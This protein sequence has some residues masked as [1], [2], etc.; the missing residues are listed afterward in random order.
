MYTAAYTQPP[1]G[2]DRSADR[3]F[4]AFHALHVFN[5][6]DKYDL[7]ALARNASNKFILTLGCDIY[8][9][10]FE[11]IIRELYDNCPDNALSEAMR[12]IVVSR[13]VEAEQLLLNSSTFREIIR[14][15]VLFAIEFQKL[16]LET[17]TKRQ[18]KL[19]EDEKAS[20]QK[21]I[22]GN[23]AAAQKLRVDIKDHED[24][25][26]VEARGCTRYKCTRNSCHG[27][28]AWRPGRVFPIC[29]NCGG[30]NFRR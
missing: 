18:Q 11:E 14:D 17:Q 30:S 10:N 20:L 28:F 24:R 13:S 5:I 19:M 3:S 7:P 4:Q 21:L 15:V 1:D 29:P 12:S 23:E 9:S 16:L 22:D 25:L 8:Q 2:S 6:A 27:T 26:D